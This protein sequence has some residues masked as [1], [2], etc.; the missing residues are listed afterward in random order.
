MAHTH[1]VLIKYG[2]NKQQYPHKSQ[3]FYNL[4]AVALNLFNQPQSYPHTKR[5]HLKNRGKGRAG[6]QSGSLSTQKYIQ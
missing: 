6:R 5:L 1:I 3:P 4:L 2:V